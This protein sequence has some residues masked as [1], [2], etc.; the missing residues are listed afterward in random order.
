[1][2]G[3]FRGIEIFSIVFLVV[4]FSTLGCSREDDDT[5]DVAVVSV[6]DLLSVEFQYPAGTSGPEWQLSDADIAYLL[7][8]HTSDWYEREDPEWREKGKHGQLL[9]QFG[10]I[11]E[12]RYLIAFDRNPGTRT[13]EQ[14]IAKSEA[15]YRLFPD[16]DTLHALRQATLLPV[17]LVENG[18]LVVIMPPP[19]DEWG[20]MSDEERWEAARKDP[21]K[22]VAHQREL[23]VASYGDIPEVHAYLD[24]QLK[25]LKGKPLTDE[26]K[27]SRD[28]SLALFWKIDAERE[29]ANH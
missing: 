7:A 18:I 1:M 28:Q 20:N 29:A 13:R 6:E 24:I 3:V 12:V 25:L 17:G 14:Y 27:H 8:T 16:E 15:H 26:E 23:L 22:F 10:D 21:E 11:P 9:K 19:S 4:L 2:K 5:S